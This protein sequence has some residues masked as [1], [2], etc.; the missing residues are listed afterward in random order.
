MLP[1]SYAHSP[2]QTNVWPSTFGSCS[3]AA[4]SVTILNTEPGVYNPC[5]QR[6]R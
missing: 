2:E 5:R 3:S 6:L 4:A 1:P